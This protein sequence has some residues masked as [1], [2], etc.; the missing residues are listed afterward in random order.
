MNERC[1]MCGELIARPGPCELCK[2]MER[3][4]DGSEVGNPAAYR[5]EM[6][7]FAI[8]AATAVC[9]A[10]ARRMSDAEKDD[11]LRI[12]SLELIE[13]RFPKKEKP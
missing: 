5:G 2:D 9:S 7:S 4:T 1:P 8:A 12:L 13:R 3:K 6:V 10:L 11:Y